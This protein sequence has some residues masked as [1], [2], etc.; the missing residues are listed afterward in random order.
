MSFRNSSIIHSLDGRSG[1]RSQCALSL[2]SHASLRNEGILSDDDVEELSGESRRPYASANSSPKWFNDLAEIV[3][4]NGFTVIPTDGK[5]P[6]PPRWSNPKPTDANWLSKVVKA[7]RYPHLNLGIVCGRVLGVDLDADD[8]ALLE[9]LEAAARHHLG[10]SAYRRVGREG[11]SLLLYRPADGELIPSTKCGGCVEILSE[12]R[13]FVA[14]GRHPAGHEYR[15][16]HEG[17]A[18]VQ[19]TDLPPVTSASILDF[20]MA[21]SQ[22][23]QSARSPIAPVPSTRIG[24]YDRHIRRDHRNLVVD[25]REAFF[26]AKLTAAVY[27]EDNTASPDKIAS[28]VAI[29]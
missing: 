12:G 5:R 17:P 22:I 27:A 29:R 11:R 4:T 16:T 8:P 10:P 24:H 7:N 14:Y 23:V 21:A 13:Q 9:Q 18:F 6:V 1:E 3:A 2:H 19:V 20:C 15:W 26:L 25:G 28:A